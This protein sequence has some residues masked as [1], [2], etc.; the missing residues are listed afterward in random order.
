MTKVEK[1]SYKNITEN[2]DDEKKTS[3]VFEVDINTDKL[4]KETNSSI[5]RYFIENT[6]DSDNGEDDEDDHSIDCSVQKDDETLDNENTIEDDEEEDDEE[7][8]ET[9]END[10]DNEDDEDLDSLNFT[11]DDD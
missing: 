9:N 6:D 10:D 7:E 5:E 4:K 3:I 2:E 11:F 1:D 8:C